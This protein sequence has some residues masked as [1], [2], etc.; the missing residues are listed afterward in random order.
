M[1][2]LPTLQ[3][4]WESKEIQGA[5]LI[6]ESIALPSLQGFLESKSNEPI[7]QF[8]EPAVDGKRRPRPDGPTGWRL[9]ADS[10]EQGSG[11]GTVFPVD[12]DDNGSSVEALGQAVQAASNGGADRIHIECDPLDGE[13]R[14]VTVDL[15]DKSPEVAAFRA[16]GGQ[17]MMGPDEVKP[18][19][20]ADQEQESTGD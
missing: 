3:E 15:L 17:I 4:F 10:T 16:A 19:V 18:G 1:K 14:E 11:G 5:Q 6:T 8:Q 9:S 20:G 13:E 12:L 2:Q 7:L